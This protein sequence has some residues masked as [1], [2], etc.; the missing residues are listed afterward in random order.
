MADMKVAPGVLRGEVKR[1]FIV[2]NWLH[3]FDSLCI[4]YSVYQIHKIT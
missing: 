2:E 3:L 4:I 1:V